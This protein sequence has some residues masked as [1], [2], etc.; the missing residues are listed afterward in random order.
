MSPLCQFHHSGPIHTLCVR[1]CPCDVNVV[2]HPC[3]RGSAWTVRMQ[4]KICGPQGQLS[5]TRSLCLSDLWLSRQLFIRSTSHLTGVLLRTQGSAVLSVKLLGWAVLQKAASSNAGGQS[6][7]PFQ[8]GTFS[9]GTDQIYRICLW[10][11]TRR[12]A[13]INASKPLQGSYRP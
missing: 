3:P 5:V 11:N 2:I 12:V 10:K 9:M 8:M 4:P 6:I 7:G 1:E 13:T